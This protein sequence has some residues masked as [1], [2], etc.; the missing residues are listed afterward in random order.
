MKHTNSTYAIIG[1]NEKCLT[2][3]N[4]CFWKDPNDV[5]NAVR[6]RSQ[7]ENLTITH[8]KTID[9]NFK[10]KIKMII[11]NCVVKFK[12]KA[13]EIIIEPFTDRCLDK[14]K[15]IVDFFIVL[16]NMGFYVYC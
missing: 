14:K 4:K 5:L 10:Q 3:T 7:L 8:W 13:I 6:T 12:E 15:K 11:N 2:R 9:R 16:F 1:S